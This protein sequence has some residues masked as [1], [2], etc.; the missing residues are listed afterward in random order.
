MAGT[1][2]LKPLEYVGIQTHG[3]QFFGRTAE[4]AELL[5]GELGNIGIV[6]LRNVRAFL[7]P[8]NAV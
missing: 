1:I 5:V 8:G 3:H 6:E 4:L 2:L 7:P